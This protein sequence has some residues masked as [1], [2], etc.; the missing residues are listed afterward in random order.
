MHGGAPG[1]GAPR[2]NENALKHGAY[3]QEAIERR[4]GIREFIRKSHDLIHNM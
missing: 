2:A 1:F 3:M 4:K